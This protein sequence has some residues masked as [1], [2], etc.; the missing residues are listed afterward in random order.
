MKLNLLIKA[1]KT[2]LN[3]Q[4]QS[5]ILLINVKIVDIF[6]IYV[7]DNL[8][9]NIYE[10]DKFHAQLSWAWIKFDNR[11]GLLHL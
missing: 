10:Q 3:H 5:F 6:I 4:S 8:A 9:I 2:K 11:G 7:Q 1:A